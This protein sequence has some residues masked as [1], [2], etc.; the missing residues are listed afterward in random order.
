M[1]LV[2]TL[3]V[4][5]PLRVLRKKP[6]HGVLAALSSLWWVRRRAGCATLDMASRAETLEGIAGVISLRR[7]RVKEMAAVVLPFH[8][9]VLDGEFARV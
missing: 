1:I 9:Q 4:A 7:A 5:K 8:L 3:S 2:S 6:G